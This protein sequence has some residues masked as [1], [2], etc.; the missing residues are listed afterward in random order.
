MPRDCVIVIYLGSEQNLKGYFTKMLL[1]QR[2]TWEEK[3]KEGSWR[4]QP[5]KKLYNHMVIVK[6]RGEAEKGSRQQNKRTS[7]H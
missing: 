2:E 4:E 7:D 5:S 3:W 6:N 1:K